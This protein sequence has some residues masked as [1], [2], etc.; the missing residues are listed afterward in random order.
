M[1]FN[2]N[3]VLFIVVLSITSIIDTFINV[4]TFFRGF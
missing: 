4:L 2:L 1:R 3:E